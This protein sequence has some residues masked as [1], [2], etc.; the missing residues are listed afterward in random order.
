MTAQE[1]SLLTEQAHAVVDQFAKVLERVGVASIRRRV[2]PRR[3]P[4]KGR[5]ICLFCVNPQTSH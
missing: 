5:A 1:V 3:F 4:H 2:S